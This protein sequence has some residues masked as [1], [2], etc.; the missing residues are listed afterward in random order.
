MS[1][2]SALNR[3]E[4]LLTVSASAI[5]ATTSQRPLGVQLEAVRD[6]LAKD[7]DQTLKAIA[8]AGYT[9]VEGYARRESIV[10][11]PKIKQYGLNLR[12]CVIE[13][14][15]I[16]ADWDNYPQFKQLSLKDA[17]DSLK[18]AGVEYCVMGA[19]PLGARGDGDD[20]F[21]RT[22]DRMNAAG[23]LCRKAGMKFAWPNQDFEFQGTPGLRPIDIYRDRLDSKLVTL[24]ID[25]V[26]LAAARL[27][28]VEVLKQ[29]KGRVS[30]VRLRNKAKDAFAPIAQGEIDFA[31]VM[32]AAQSAGAKYYFVYDDPENLPKAIAYLKKL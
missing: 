16:T 4:W 2:R 9:E 28:P 13:T 20:F 17:I 21:R 30:L 19:I 15:L 1:P 5:A 8:A 12:S 18:E 22:A 24:E 23:D 31:A 29:W 6:N 3:R 10:L 7:P 32:K 14:P 25:V 27:N 11:A 26:W